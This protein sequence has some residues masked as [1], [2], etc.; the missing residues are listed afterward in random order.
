MNGRVGAGPGPMT[1]YI[2]RDPRT[3]KPINVGGG[4]KGPRVK[5][6]QRGRWAKL[7][8]DEVLDLATG[9]RDSLR[10]IVDGEPLNF[11]RLDGIEALVLVKGRRAQ[12]AHDAL[13]EACMDDDPKIRVAALHAMPEVAEQRSG[14]LFDHLSVMLDD[15]DAS[16]RRE[17][18]RSLEAMTPVFPSGVE[19]ILVN[20]LRS[21]DPELAKSA[22]AGLG[23]MGET[24]PSVV[25]VHVDS[26][27]LEDEDHLRRQGAKALQKV[28]AKAGHE[29][30]DLVG[31]ALAD[32]DVEVRRN[33]A[34]CL[35]RMI[36]PA[37]RMAVILAEKTLYDE[38]GRV[39]DK[40]LQVLKRVDLDA[41]RAKSII[42]AGTA[43]ALPEVR[44]ACLEMLPR[45]MG[46]DDLRAFAQDR[47]QLEKDASLR[48]MLLNMAS[49][50]A[51]EGSE[52]EKNRFLAPAEPVP[53]LDMEVVAAQEQELGLLGRPVM[54]EQPP[55]EGPA[56][57]QQR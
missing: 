35:P 42:V 9:R 46:E 57:D 37:P 38:D 44:R 51:L 31:W 22:W 33:A 16:V 55:E 49:D 47:L 18:C 39:R 50:A 13:A 30:W 28:I 45:F 53:Q 15:P 27:L 8:Q 32:D 10:R 48:A 19:D 4:G 36:G 24:W 40:A 41:G 21:K 5:A 1:D 23:A 29:A 11:V 14:E 54:T 7:G 3:G 56:E 2:A 6:R 17:A 25:C 20:A 12:E 52:D 43:H 34:A 26:L